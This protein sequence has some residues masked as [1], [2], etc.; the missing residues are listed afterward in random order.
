MYENILRICSYL[1]WKV[2]YGY[3]GLLGV[4]SGSS[5][6]NVHAVAD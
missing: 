4:L 1:N 2:G 5:D 6:F 3:G